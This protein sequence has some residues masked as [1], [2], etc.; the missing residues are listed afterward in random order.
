M[1][2][3]SSNGDHVKGLLRF[4]ANERGYILVL[5]RFATLCK[6]GRNIRLRY[7][8]VSS[9]FFLSPSL[10][11]GFSNEQTMRGER[12]RSHL[13]WI[14]GCVYV[15]LFANLFNHVPIGRGIADQNILLARGA[16]RI[17]TLTLRCNGPIYFCA[18]CMLIVA[19]ILPLWTPFSVS[20]PY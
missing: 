9:L 19:S 8:G 11:C 1:R 4:C 15:A 13:D 20:C 14:L 10:S 2:G 6:I 5:S 12:K 3:I 16:L 17:A 7:I 18:T